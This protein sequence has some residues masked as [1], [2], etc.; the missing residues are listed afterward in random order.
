MHNRE[1]R[2][3]LLAYFWIT[4]FKMQSVN[5]DPREGPGGGQCGWRAGWRT[6]WFA[7]VPRESNVADGGSLSAETQADSDRDAYQSFYSLLGGRDEEG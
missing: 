7:R 4:V 3:T 6:G 1:K 2:P 5:F